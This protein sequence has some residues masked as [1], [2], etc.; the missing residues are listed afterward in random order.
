VPPTIVLPLVGLLLALVY[1]AASRLWEPMGAAEEA[2][3]RR[4][5]QR[6]C[7][8]CLSQAEVAVGRVALAAAA[9]GPPVRRLLA[10][11]GILGPPDPEARR[12]RTAAFLRELDLDPAA[13]L[14]RPSEVMGLTRESPRVSN[15]KPMISS[16]RP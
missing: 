13:I 1:G 10:A 2:A 12:A 5:R 7:V 3:G 14:G 4:E 8:T 9:L 16:W 6:M 15:L 11:L